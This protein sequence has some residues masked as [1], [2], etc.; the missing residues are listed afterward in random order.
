MSE[1]LCRQKDL[2]VDYCM[3][4]MHACDCHASEDIVQCYMY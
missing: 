1:S 4:T 2:R 3:L